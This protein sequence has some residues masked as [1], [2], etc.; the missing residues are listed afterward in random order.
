MGPI[1]H[2]ARGERDEGRQA[3]PMTLPE[4]VLGRG[5]QHQESTRLTPAFLHHVH[6]ALQT[7]PMGRELQGGSAGPRTSKTYACAGHTVAVLSL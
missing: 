6:A 1:I 7:S 2:Q 3:G 4:G 5:A